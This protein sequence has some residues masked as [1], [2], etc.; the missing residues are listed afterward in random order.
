[1]TKTDKPSTGMLLDGIFSSEAIDSSG[2]IVELDGMDVSTIVDG[3]GLVNYE[4]K[5]E[6]DGGF[7]K[8]VVGK[9][10]YV[11]KIFSAEDCEN[12]RQRL[13]FQ[14]LGKGIPFLYGTV[15]LFDG[16]G[17]SGAQNLAAAIRDLAANDEPILLRWS[18]EGA[19][20]KKDGNKIKSSIAKKVALTWKPCNK[21]CVAGLLADPNAPQGFKKSESEVIL[22]PFI[23]TMRHGKVL[24]SLLTIRAL[25]K[26]QRVEKAQLPEIAPGF[27][28]HFEG[29]A[30]D[31]SVKKAQAPAVIIPAEHQAVNHALAPKQHAVLADKTGPT[32][33][34]AAATVRGKKLRPRPSVKSPEFDAKKGVLHTPKGT[35]KAYLPSHDGPE[36]EAYYQS[37]LSSP[38]IEG[39][40]DTALGNWTKLHKLLKAGKLPEEVIMHGVMFSQLSPNKPVPVQEIQFARLHD[41]MKQT[42]LDPRKPGFDKIA[43]HIVNS[44]DQVPELSSEEFRTNLAY[45]NQGMMPRFND[46]G[47]R[48]DNKGRV[49]IASESTGRMPGDLLSSSPLMQDFFKRSAEYHK[50][51]HDVVSWVNSHKHDM[52]GAVSVLMDNKKQAELWNARRK[53]A[54]ASGKP[55]SG[56]FSGLDIPGIKVKTGL[57]AYGMLGGGNSIVPDTHEVRH[58]YGLDLKKD[59]ESIEYLKNIHWEPGNIDRV[60]KPLNE[61]YLNNHPALKYTLNHP[62]WGSHFE[63]PE[64]AL[65]PSFWRHWLTIA[66]HEKSLGMSNVSH[67][68]GTT[69]APYW[70]AIRPHIEKSEN[71]GD[72]PD[73]SVA[74]RT[75]MLHQ[76]YV[77]DYGEIPAMFLYYHH[78][79]PELLDA[80]EKR[81]KN[82]PDMGFLVKQMEYE[83]IELKKSI[84]FEQPK[85]PDVR[86]VSLKI[87]GKMHD[88][89]R[90]MVHNGRIHHLEDYHGILESMLPEGR[91]DTA[92]IS[93]L[94]GLQ[95]SQNFSVD[96]HNIDKQPAPTGEVHLDQ[97]PLSAT[98]RPAVFDY[99]RAGMSK[100][101]VLEFGL[102]GAALD[103]AKLSDPEL[104]L[105]AQNVKDGLA[106]L[107]YPK[108]LQKDEGESISADDALAH[109]RAAVQAGHV[110]PDIE[111]A[112]TRH[113]YED[114]MVP[115]IGN[116]YAY[117]QFRSKNKPGVYVSIDA[118]S[119]KH[120][121]DN[122]GHDAGDG[123]ITGI[124]NALK[125]ASAKIG[126]GKVF[127]P[128][129][130]EFVAHFPTHSDAMTF[131]RH[132]T[133]HVDQIPP[134][135]GKHKLSLSFG[136][137]NDFASADRALYAAKT[138]KVNPS[139]GKSFEPHNTPHLAHSMVLGHE[140]PLTNPHGPKAQV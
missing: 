122:Y 120:V 123:A 32:P 126:S 106:T 22:D 26:A 86:K 91:L 111:R 102:H 117:Q 11:K 41:A 36:S 114:K 129:G 119:F 137:G 79:V 16:A 127:R 35:F 10:I 115:G 46:A 18:I 84:E 88:A 66:P 14:K 20:L 30:D 128:G 130:D 96:N 15:R 21:T 97:D 100:P 39:A 3:G 113:I 17:H 19:T 134:I 109:I 31:Y 61:W 34:P 81:E 65:F 4:H 112:L 58:L 85:H 105:I 72:G 138:Q 82:K 121:N 57:Y 90:F 67:Q 87:K 38:K 40:M 2:E 73:S 93:R 99:H 139:T 13:F 51:H 108:K 24:A 53:Q 125:N 25:I 6:D 68:A 63:K 45:R 135:E 74:M 60:M 9:I 69:H 118:N 83:F 54:L 101:S 104:A 80:A 75:A 116:K 50:V 8:E 1:M 131:M 42:G 132:A 49:A 98:A 29:V 47:Q 7:G 103:G 124:G 64:D 94:H 12:E 71:D 95:W 136:V 33:K 76:Q 92:A 5:G 62:K 27:E 56:E 107:R 59:P 133:N 28:S 52:L 70:D 89:G 48:L 140:G 37:L 77:R 44:P 23:D 43:Q 78:I 110:H 55:D